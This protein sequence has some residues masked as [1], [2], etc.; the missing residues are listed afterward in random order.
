M[1]SSHNGSLGTAITSAG[2]MA[3]SPLFLNYD[4]IFAFNQSRVNQLTLECWRGSAPGAHRTLPGWH[5]G[6]AARQ[7]RR[8]ERHLRMTSRTANSC[9]ARCP[10]KSGRGRESKGEHQETL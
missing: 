9:H 7:D 3:I 1:L 6:H 5:S 10:T 4:T 8:R 2:A